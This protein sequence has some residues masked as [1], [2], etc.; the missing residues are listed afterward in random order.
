[1]ANSIFFDFTLPNSTS[2]FYFSLF[3]TISLFFNFSRPFLSRNG[4]LLALFLF[5]PGFL[6]VQE[7]HSPLPERPPP[8]RTEPTAGQETE[9]TMDRVRDNR[10]RT[11]FLGY[12]WLLGASGYWL[13][14]CLV[15]LSTTKR[16][17]PSVNLAVPALG[18]LTVSLFVCLAVVAFQR[19]ADPWEPGSWLPLAN[20][21]ESTHSETWSPGA[22]VRSTVAD[23]S[24]GPLQQTVLKS[25]ALIGHFLI[26]IGLYVMGS[27]RF[28][29]RQTGAMAAALYLLL[30]YTAFHIS[31]V[32][33]VWPAVFLLWA[34]VLY[35]N[36]GWS[37]GL[38]GL[39]MASFLF[40]ALLLPAWI[41]FYRGRSAGRLLLGVVVGMSV[42][43]LMM[44][45][46]AY[47]TTLTPW[48]W[49][50]DQLASW[51]P[52][53]IPQTES[54]WTGTHWAYR[55]PIFIAYLAFVL[56]TIFWPPIRDLGN[57]VAIS[58][59]VVIGLQFWQG[60]QGGLYVLWYAPLIIV[61]V[62]RPNLTEHHPPMV[63]I[64]PRRMVAAADW[65]RRRVAGPSLPA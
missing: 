18:F 39:A 59:A 24:T 17:L 44:L 52:W 51:Q 3:L 5:V 23:A 29:D 31:Q 45:A 22:S 35:R 2:W 48:F 40:P 53:Q 1:M 64:W 58:T 27:W 20:G 33:H 56:T 42:G 62:V 37:G 46:L 11:N 7:S 25:V 12:L 4:D 34:L 50:Q 21:K 38:L 28:Q 43:A 30:P 49:S 55:L 15:D 13:I 8:V 65:C 61:M 41:Q 10:N 63:A 36:P 60:N 6:L 14:R 19:P 26:L 54:L 47:F 9:S 32:T 16:P 57:L